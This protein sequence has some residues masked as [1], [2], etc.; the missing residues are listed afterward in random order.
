MYLS[1]VASLSAH[2]DVMFEEMKTDKEATKG[3][4]A[5]LGDVSW[6]S[7]KLN[8]TE[9]SEDEADPPSGARGYSRSSSRGPLLKQLLDRWQ[10][11][12]KRSDKVCAER[13]MHL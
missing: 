9:E 5:T 1:V 12:V 6:D 7:V 4:R 13:R 2:A 3:K 11:P 8:E 10:E